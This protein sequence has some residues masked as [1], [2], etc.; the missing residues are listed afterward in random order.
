MR[1]RTSRRHSGCLGPATSRSRPR[2]LKH[3]PKEMSCKTS[4]GSLSFIQM[5][6]T[7]A[8]RERD[9]LALSLSSHGTILRGS[10]LQRSVRHSDGC[11][12]CACGEGHPLGVLNVNDPGG[13][14]R[15]LSLHPKQ[16]PRVRQYLENYRRLQQTLETLSELNQQVLRADRVEARKKDRQP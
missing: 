16:V 7:Q 13:K 1:G 14:T 15:P 10:L 5:T 9:R 12:K 3:F 8:I 4:P 6:R 11:Q 2:S